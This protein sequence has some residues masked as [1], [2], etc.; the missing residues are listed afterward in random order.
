MLEGLSR[1][2]RH[3][4]FATRCPP[5]PAR[6]GLGAGDSAFYKSSYGRALEL[7][8]GATCRFLSTVD[9]IAKHFCYGLGAP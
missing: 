4:A 2:A 6:S 8:R 7:S 3:L 5:A 9:G 1:L